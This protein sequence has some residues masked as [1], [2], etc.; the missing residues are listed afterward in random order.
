M[1][2][3]E[4]TEID[5][6]MVKLLVIDDEPFIRKLIVRLLI[7]IGIKNVIEADNGLK[8]INKIIQSRTNFDLIICDLEMPTLNGLDFLKTLR[9]HPQVKAP[10]T[11]VVILTGHSDE[12][13]IYDAVM[14]G[15]HGF[16]TKPVSR[17]DLEAKVKQALT[18][19][20]IDAARLRRK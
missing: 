11:P 5:Y 17:N 16:L 9:K 4:Y 10:Q 15:I 18:G 19:A 1:S 8:G 14:L 3:I 6:S 13:N 12:D 2:I 20:P 7:E